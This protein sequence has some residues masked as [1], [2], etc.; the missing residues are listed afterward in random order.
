MRRLA[1]DPAAARDLGRRAAAKIASM[2]DEPAFVG[3]LVD[4]LDLDR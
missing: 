3:R 1:G 4:L 2:P